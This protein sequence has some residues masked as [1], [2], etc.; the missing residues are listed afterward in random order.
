[1]D[2]IPLKADRNTIFKSVENHLTS[3]GLSIKKID[4]TRP[5][6]G[7]FVIDESSLSTFVKLFFPDFEIKNSIKEQ[8]L[9]PK[10]LLVEP[11]KRLSWQ[12]HHRRSEI[13]TIT[14]GKVGVIL[15]ENDEQKSVQTFV[16]GDQVKIKQGE[17][18]RLVGLDEWG[19][20]AEIWKHSDPTHPSDE[21]DIVR[22]DDDFGR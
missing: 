8:T 19:V 21:Q 5:W 20:V 7:F 4:E 2:A 17:R 11:G 18:H 3:K 13:W 15:S 10:I 12:Y 6:G 9:S 22:L 16:T 1:M 14:N